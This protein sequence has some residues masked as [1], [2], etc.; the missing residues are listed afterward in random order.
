MRTQSL[1]SSTSP[2]VSHRCYGR[3]LGGLLWSLFLG[4]PIGVAGQL[5]WEAHQTSGG[6]AW[7]ALGAG[8]GVF[9]GL[10]SQQGFTSSDLTNWTADAA[11]ATGMFGGQLGR[12][13]YL[14]DRFLVAGVVGFG[15]GIFVSPDGR[16][17]VG[18]RGVSSQYPLDTAFGNGVFVAVGQQDTLLVSR[19]GTNWTGGTLNLSFRFLNTL[20][21]VAYGNGRFVAVGV[22]GGAFG[23]GTGGGQI[24]VSSD[25][26]NWA[27]LTPAKAPQFS[28]VTWGDGRFVAV[29]RAGGYAVSMEGTNWSL[30]SAG[31]AA[32]LND[33]AFGGQ[34]FVAAGDAGT[35]L[36]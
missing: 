21:G 5:A 24:L 20:D 9:V 18:A 28:G 11:V 17:W 35:V 10:T 14:A 22:L 4:G 30:G 16:G 25:G 34:L 36:S 15:G 31:V 6:S 19:D 13:R 3:G 2:A 12:V 27:D 8:G 29:G 23:S 7:Q 32:N 1:L 26:T 33:V